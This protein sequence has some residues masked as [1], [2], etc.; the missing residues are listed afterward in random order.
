[1]NGPALKDTGTC[2]NCGERFAARRPKF[3]PECGQ[4]TDLRP[5]TLMEFAQQFGGAYISTE[6]ALWRSL[7]LLLTRPGALTREYLQ[8][9]RKRYVLPLRLYLTVSVV[10]LLIIQATG[11][12][13]IRTGNMPSQPR[14]MI[15]PLGLGEAGIRDGVF[16]CTGLPDWLCVRL[17]PQLDIDTGSIARKAEEISRG[18]ISHLGAAM[19]IAMPLFAAWLRLVY[20]RRGLRYTEHL[21][22]ALHLHTAWFLLLLV[23]ALPSARWPALVALAAGSLYALLAGRHVYG[24]HWVP[25]LARFAVLVTL[26][27][28]TLVA[29]LRGVLIWTLLA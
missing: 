2:A 4:E 8:G 6:G 18:A 13:T 20:A 1:M 17:R 26:Y 23:A 5:P 24:G 27:G 16:F 28:V 9:R 3:C 10:V 14:G 7:R 12:L 21:V 29:I 15:V 25:R 19:F 22:F 11:T